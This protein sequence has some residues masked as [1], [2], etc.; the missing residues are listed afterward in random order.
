MERPV[1][2]FKNRTKAEAENNTEEFKKYD[3][4]IKLYYEAQ[5]K[6]LLKPFIKPSNPF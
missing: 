5:E 4:L 3:K 2:L 6:V 1:D